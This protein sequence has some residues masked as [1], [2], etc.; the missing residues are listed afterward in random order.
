M[1]HK[2]LLASNSKGKIREYKEMFSSIPDIELVTIGVK[3]IT[4]I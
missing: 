3:I 1:K 4:I 2:I